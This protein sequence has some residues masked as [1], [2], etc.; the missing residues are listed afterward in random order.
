MAVK[1]KK[2]SAK[3]SANTQNKCG[4]CGRFGA[5]VIIFTAMLSLSLIISISNSVKLFGE[6]SKDVLKLEAR[7][8]RLEFCVAKNISPC[9]YEKLRE[10]NDAHDSS[11]KFRP[12]V[13]DGFIR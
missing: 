8:E 9:S 11:E 13:D 6:T 5:L 4:K 10:W 12:Q 2:Q 1:T 3:N 7:V